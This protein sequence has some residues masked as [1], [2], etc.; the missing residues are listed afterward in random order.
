MCAAMADSLLFL[1]TTSRLWT[2]RYSYS[3]SP[4]PPRRRS[5][6]R[7]GP[8]A[9]ALVQLKAADRADLDASS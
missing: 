7:A 6:R 9:D 1:T 4:C 2:G 5:S 3:L 8:C